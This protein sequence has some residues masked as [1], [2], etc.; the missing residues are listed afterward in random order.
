MV[1]VKEALTT[2]S[3][4]LSAEVGFPSLLL[5]DGLLQADLAEAIAVAMDQLDCV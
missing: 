2:P 4:Y 1:S 3:L 5:T